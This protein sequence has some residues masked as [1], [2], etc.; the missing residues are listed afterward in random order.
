VRSKN[1]MSRLCE[2]SEECKS[3][4][5]SVNSSMHEEKNTKL[6]DEFNKAMLALKKILVYG[7]SFRKNLE[8]IEEGDDMSKIKIKLKEPLIKILL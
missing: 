2:R 8:E 1:P 4:N 7:N 6:D 5:Q 3:R